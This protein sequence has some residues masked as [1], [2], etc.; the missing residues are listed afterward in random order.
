MS[1]TPYLDKLIDTSTRLNKAAAYGSRNLVVQAEMDL[2]VDSINLHLANIRS[3]RSLGSRIGCLETMAHTMMIFF[4]DSYGDLMKHLDK[5]EVEEKMKKEEEEKA[6]KM[7]KEEE[8]E[9]KKK[10]VALIADQKK[11]L[12]EF[13]ETAKNTL[14]AFT[15]LKLDMKQ[16]GE[17]IEKQ[18]EEAEGRVWELNEDLNRLE[19]LRADDQEEIRRLKRVRCKMCRKNSKLTEENEELKGVNLEFS[20]EISKS[21]QYI[22]L[23]T[24]RAESAEMERDVLKE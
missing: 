8:E 21:A 16:V 18:K 17:Q 14:E 15:T 24:G 10:M 5:E 2:A 9:E 11:A 1:S 13:M 19:A 7:K 4:R 20:K 22:D 6:D 3:Q 12:G 23:L